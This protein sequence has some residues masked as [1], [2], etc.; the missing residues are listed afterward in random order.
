MDYNLTAKL[1]NQ[2]VQNVYFNKWTE[3]VRRIP[4][5]KTN[6]QIKWVFL[7]AIKTSVT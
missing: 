1:I 2:P 4:I 3:E 6:K 7:S 5:E